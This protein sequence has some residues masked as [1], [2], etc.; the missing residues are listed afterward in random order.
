MDFGV[1]EDFY[2]PLGTV[3]LSLRLPGK[4]RAHMRLISTTKLP[5]RKQKYL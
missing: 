5:L 1:L 3:L 4:E 2:F